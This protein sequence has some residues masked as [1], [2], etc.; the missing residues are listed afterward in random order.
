MDKHP[1]LSSCITEAMRYKKLGDAVL[2]RLSDEQLHFQPHADGNSI[3]MLV[4]HLS[5]NMRSRF[6]DFLS[7]DGEKSFRQ[8][9]AEFEPVHWPKATVL[10]AWQAGWEI[11]LEVLHALTEADLS[12]TVYIRSEPHS[13]YDALQRQQA[14][15]P[16]HIGQMTLLGKWLLGE[17]WQSLSIPKN[18]SAAYLQQMEEKYKKP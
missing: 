12:K 16:Y 1:Y 2:E 14:H 3:A 17:K 7:S 11:Y 18:Q 5:G 13:V 8:R 9:D 4:H 15:Y 10:A 6:T